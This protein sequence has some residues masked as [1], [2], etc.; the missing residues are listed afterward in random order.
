MVRSRIPAPIVCLLLATTIACGD[1]PTVVR[2]VETTEHSVEVQGSSRSYRL[3]VPESIRDADRAPLLVIFHGATQ[4]ASGIELLSWLFPAAEATGLLVAYPEATGDYWNTP[5]SPPAY[6]SAPDVPFVDALIADVAARH[7]VDTRRVYVAGFSNGA[8]FAQM[9][10]CLRGNAIAGLG[11]VGA[12]MSASVSLT[13]P[14]ER[15]VPTVVLFGDRD[16]QFFWDDGLAAAVG[17]LG[18]GGTAAWLA[19]HN[20]CDPTPLITPV[21]DAIDDGTEVELWRHED[22]TGDAAVDFYRIVGGGHTWPGSPLNLDPGFGRKTRRIDAS[23]IM[24]DF[25]APHVSPGG[26]A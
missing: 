12:G 24:V 19:E 16:P 26:G 1:G 2:D 5:N 11:L 21:G 22:C 17:M 10:A 23:R 8:I 3:H 20:G 15:P 4:S 14:W 6:W 18:G 13:C 7:G 25:F 9:V